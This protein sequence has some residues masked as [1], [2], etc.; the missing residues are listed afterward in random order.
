MARYLDTKKQ[1]NKV[2]V[3]VL[4]FFEIIE[5]RTK[6]FKFASSFEKK[7]KFLPLINDKLSKG[8]M[9]S[10]LVNKSL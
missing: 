5:S 6:L 8:E 10:H 7:K 4:D 2:S 3:T 9:K 1:T